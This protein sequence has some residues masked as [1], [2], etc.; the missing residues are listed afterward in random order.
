MADPQSF[1]DDDRAELVAYLDG[2][3]GADAQRRVEARLN[4]DAIAR[5][6]AD[7]LKRAWDMLD[8]L[9][10]SEPSLDFTERTLDRVS[11]LQIATAARGSQSKAEPIA[12]PWYRWRGLA[13]AGWAAAALVALAL[14][15]AVGP[16]KSAEPPIESDP[17]LTEK[18]RVIEHL[19]LYLAAENLDYLLALDQPE[20]FAD[21]G[22]GR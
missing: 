19:P 20:L 18:P 17:I 10:R 8:F 1:T 7:T 14:G 22:S 6:E 4:T 9:P 2:E 16:R 13:A 5:A 15:Y 11:S 21:D 3:L 12:I